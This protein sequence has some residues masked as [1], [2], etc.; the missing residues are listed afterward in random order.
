MQ[1]RRI[2]SHMRAVFC[3][4][5][6]LATSVV[7]T[8][9]ARADST[10]ESGRWS[11]GTSAWMLAN[12][13][14]DSPHFAYLEADVTL[15]E[16]GALAFGALT[17]R[18]HAPI[19]IPYGSA[20]GDPAEDYPGFVRSVGAGVGWRQRLYRGLTA[21]AWAFQLLQLY[22]EDHQPVRAGYQ[23]FLQARVGWRFHVGEPGFWFEPAVAFNAWPIEVGRPDLFREKDERWPSYFLFEPWLNLGWSW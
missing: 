16:P 15:G 7:A 5:V 13:L 4:L 8:P 6:A 18:Y 14:P 21:S 12:A 2:L 11:L 10:T 20:Q 17:W 3:G 1:A 19:G 23:L 9:I 22:S